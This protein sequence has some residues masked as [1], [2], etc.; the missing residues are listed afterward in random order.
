[1]T[2]E[3]RDVQ[4]TDETL[5]RPSAQ[6]R[7]PAVRPHE[8]P[9]EADRWQQADRLFAR[10]LEVPE[11]E[12]AA[13]LE[14]ACRD[15]GELLE[16][17]QQLLAFDDA[18]DSFLAKPLA[19]AEVDAL[20]GGSDQRVGPYR[21][22]GQ[23]GS[24]GMGTVYLAEQ[25]EPVERKV[26]LKVIKAGMDSEQVL[27]RFEGERQALAL[28]DHSNVAR[29][30]DA[31]CTDAGR[32]YFA[33]EY[34]PGHEITT[35]C[36]RAELGFRGRV[37][38]FLQVCDGVQH[39]HQ[40]GLIHRDLKPSNI[41]VKSSMTEP[42]TVKII[43]FGVAKSLQRK[44][45][46]HAA[47]TQLGTFVG[48]PVYS[49]PEQIMGRFVETDTRSDIYSLGVVLYELLVGAAPYG[50]DDFEGKTQLEIV[51]MLSD[52]EPPTPISRFST[53][54][55][56][57]EA[58]AKRRSLSVEQMQR[59]LRGDIAWILLKCLERRPEDRYPSV[60]ELRKDLERWLDDRPIEARPTTGFYRL[61]K[62]VR[63]HRTAVTVASLVAVAL[64]AT[65]A[66]AVVG[67]VRA[68]RAAEEAR[69]AADFQVEQLQSIDPAAM[70]AGLRTHLQE[71]VRRRLADQDLEPGAIEADLATL[72]ALLQHANFTD[73]SLALLDEHI[74]DRAEAAIEDDYG[75]TPQLQAR[76]WQSVSDTQQALGQYESAVEPQERAL[77]LRRDELGSEH[78]L[79]L[80]SLRSRGR[81]R[82]LTGRLDD[83][84]ADLRAAMEAQRRVLGASN[85]DTLTT[86]SDYATVVRSRGKLAD[87]EPFYRQAV[88]GYRQVLG[89][90]D[91]STIAT[92]NNL[93]VLLQ[94]LGR[95]DDAEPLLREALDG[96]RRVSGDEHPDTLV[97]IGNLGAFLQLRGAWDEA[98]ALLRESLA[99]RRKILGD[100]HPSTL[101]AIDNLGVFLTRRG[102]LEE[103][104]TLHREALTRHREE[105]GDEHPDT[106]ISAG[107]M[108]IVLTRLGELDEAEAHLRESL[109]GMRRVLGDEHRRTLKALDSFASL[110]ETRGA[111]EQ[112]E[113]HRREALDGMRR[114]LGDEHWSTVT[115]ASRLG[116][117]LH[118]RGQH[119]ESLAL[120]REAAESARRLDAIYRFVVGESLVTSGCALAALGR[121]DEA[122]VALEEG[123]TILAEV[124][125]IDQRPE[126][127]ARG[128][129]ELYEAWH[130]AEPAQGHAAKVSRWSETLAQLEP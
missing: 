59:R 17:V 16:L 102:Q 53:G 8:P 58:I 66:A 30:Y 14:Q 127:V 31:G 54:E 112:A 43:D 67:F 41:L 80:E 5:Q 128:F 27:A 42:A 99:G 63:R 64:L 114:V 83:A 60:S 3:N 45:S 129:L 47:H 69:L 125:P 93:G 26:A 87:A 100:E 24:G 122:E 84:E 79:T 28:M 77:A 106:L 51:Q 71:S 120:S 91:L 36:D 65:T 107:Y 20:V 48:T 13:F 109:D 103:A 92:I 29:V 97:L 10:A 49:S 111:L 90:E 95:I 88:A 74:F 76:L 32:S 21:L 118:R 105:L 15:D 56:D 123:R 72:D 73:L 46:A 55:G 81:L 2:T 33:M 57:T 98:E 78:P 113:A 75:E 68:E 6:P 94:N 124:E 22:M 50:L 62:L 19:A 115:A 61:Q 39:A 116:S 11:A 38:L 70:G 96:I 85:E 110:L 1:M 40:K 37:R 101:K 34:V 126:L 104:E 121:F 130:Q 86:I 4:P 18:D 89:D 12:R 119:N 35:H 44:L 108:G 23:L 117:L 9:V 52:E 82:L 7:E 25:S